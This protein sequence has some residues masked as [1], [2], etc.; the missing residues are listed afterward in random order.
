MIRSDGF[1]PKVRDDDDDT[2]SVE[3]AAFQ[4]DYDYIAQNWGRKVAE[5]WLKCVDTQ[6]P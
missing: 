4:A 2:L 3:H 6:T 5:K 1:D